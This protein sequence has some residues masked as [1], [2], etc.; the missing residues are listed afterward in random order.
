LLHILSDSDGLC[1]DVIAD[2]LSDDP[3]VQKTFHEETIHNYLH[4]LK[5][6]GL[7]WKRPHVTNGLVYKLSE[8]LIPTDWRDVDILAMK[9][10]LRHVDI[11]NN[12][13]DQWIAKMMFEGFLTEV[14]Q[15]NQEE[16]PLDVINPLL[17]SVPKLTT[18]EIRFEYVES[19][20]FRDDEAFA[21][22]IPKL[23][24]YCKEEQW[25]KIELNR[26]ATAEEGVVLISKYQEIQ[27]L[28]PDSI[29]PDEN[30]LTIHLE[31]YELMMKDKT[32]CLWG[33]AKEWD[34]LCQ[35]P[36][37]VIQSV[38]QEPGK[39]RKT[40]QPVTVKFKLFGRLAKTYRLY[41]GE[42]LIEERMAGETEG[43]ILIEA[44]TLDTEQLVKR[45][46]KYSTQCEVISP[47]FVRQKIIQEI[48]R[49]RACCS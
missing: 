44:K 18:G 48:E 4:T 19:P 49:L 38:R 36:I 22:M 33:Y 30:T 27:Y 16:C 7:R 10:L 26:Q 28:S 46:M 21:E 25:L 32:R 6:S 31:P 2:A 8:R 17:E 5:R 11:L 15:N 37:H 42:N 9:H 20:L 34:A 23:I 3:L 47:I 35:I 39:A 29:E 24:Q 1:F 14:L 41:P 12:P 13:M 43:S 40:V 45:L